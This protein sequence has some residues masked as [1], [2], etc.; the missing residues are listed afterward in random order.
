MDWREVK[1]GVWQRP[2]G[3]I[4]SVMSSI[5]M[6]D[7][8]PLQEPIRIHVVADFT[9]PY[10][11]DQ[12]VQAFRDSWKAI[13]LL[14]SPDIATTFADGHKQYK[15]ASEQELQ[16]WLDETFTASPT[17][18]SVDEIIRERQARQTFLPAFSVS[19]QNTS[20]TI[21]KGVAVLLI[22]HWRTEASGALQIVNQLFDYTSEILSG[23]TIRDQLGNHVLASEVRL[24]TPTLDDIVMPNK[25][26]TPEA[27]ARVRK[28]FADVQLRMPCVEFPMQGNAAAPSSFVKL[29][30][31]TYH[32]AMTA[33]LLSACKSK[34]ISVTAAIHSAFLGGVWAL[35]DSRNKSRHYAALMPAQ[36]RKRLPTTSPYRDQG[37]WDAARV[38]MLTIP[39]DQDFITR[40][41]S[42]RQQYS[43]AN[44]DSWMFEDMRAVSEW[45]MKPPPEGTPAQPL[46]MPWFT[47]IGLLDGDV[48]LPEHGNI[49]I[50]NVVVWAD[51]TGPGVVLGQWTFRGQLNI[52]IH[53]NST[54][55]SDTVIEQALDLVEEALESELGVD[56][57]MAGKRILVI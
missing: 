37:A 16:S 50:E 42:L 36:V 38:L 54:Y 49:Q 5:I 1:S 27:K 15:V 11:S 12:V 39:P 32:P 8:P 43:L 41:R 17:G 47:S 24:L 29:S 45:T 9:T 31:R 14:K 2:L 30:Q 44:Q 13:R 19:L 48:L 51:P 35:A 40:A 4:E 10:S 53:W 26:S 25:D 33:S 55:H 28:H 6:V 20:G 18:A 22:S 23:T 3:G 34:G 46:S 7:H 56:M 21:S 52:E 57:G